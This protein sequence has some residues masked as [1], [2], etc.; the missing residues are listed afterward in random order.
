MPT[1]LK[2]VRLYNKRILPLVQWKDNF[3][4]YMRTYIEAVQ[5]AN[6]NLDGTIG[7]AVVPVVASGNNAINVA[8]TGGPYKGTTGLGRLM[9]FA[10]L[11]ARLQNVPVPPVAATAFHVA[12]ESALCEDGVET[13]PRTG[14][15]EYSQ[16]KED[17]GRIGTPNSV[18]NN[19][20]VNLTLNLNTLLGTDDATG[21]KVRVWLKPKQSGGAV[22]P[23]STNPAVAFETVTV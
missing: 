20:G 12:L 11:D 21:R 9:N 18:V 14:E 22:G 6:Y 3:L 23:Q 4:D 16:I 5:S 15:I 7:L 8:A 2:F 19:G 13:N 1:D 10:A 17:I